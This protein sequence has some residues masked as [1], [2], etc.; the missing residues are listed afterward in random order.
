MRHPVPSNEGRLI[1]VVRCW[2]GERWLVGVSEIRRKQSHR[3]V[4]AAWS[5]LPVQAVMGR[6]CRGPRGRSL[7]IQRARYQGLVDA[8]GDASPPR[9]ESPAT[10]VRRAFREEGRLKCCDHRGSSGANL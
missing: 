8:K 9:N 10:V 4:Q 6:P 7:G 2:G 3:Q 1:S 5:W